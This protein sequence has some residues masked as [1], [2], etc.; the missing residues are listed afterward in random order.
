MRRVL[1]RTTAL[2][3]ALTMSSGACA[4]PGNVASEPLAGPPR[5]EGFEG[6]Q[7]SAVRPQTEPDLMAWDPGSRANL[8]R[9]RHRGVVAVRYQAKGC[10]VELELLSNCI[11][12][13]GKY[14]FSPYQANEHKVAHNASELFAELPLGAA[15]LSGKVKGNRALRTDYMLAG[16]Y[17]LPPDAMFR[18]ADLRGMDCA[19]ATHVVSTLYVGGFAM[20]AGEQRAMDGR[21]TLFGLGARGTAQADVE[22]L[23]DEGDPEACRA[24]QKER[25]E[26]EGCGVPL[27]VGLTA[28]DT[29]GAPVSEAPST[30]RAPV[31]VPSA[32]RTLTTKPAPSP[33]PA[34]GAEGGAM[35]NIPAGTY[36]MGSPDGE[37]DSDEH[38]RHQVTVAAFSMDVTEVTV[39]AY[40]RCVS[41][42]PCLPLETGGACNYG[43][44][45]KASHPIN[46]VAWDK[47]G[48]YCAWA[49]KRLPSEEEWEYAARGTD[50][51]TYPWG[52]EV[53]GARVCWN[54]AGND[55][56]PGKRSGTCPVGAY[57]AGKSPFG[58][59]DMS[60]NV[61]EWTSSGWSDAYG[62]SRTTS[63]RVGRGGGWSSDDPSR[64]R[65]ALRGRYEPWAHDDFLGFRCAR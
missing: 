24:S 18:R 17:A 59:L 7:C 57:P 9:L 65:G 51:R 25:K 44:S 45:D 61:R 11:G 6:V 8:S 54:G 40:A 26:N 15:R 46:C 50:G 30:G 58:L 32:P 36:W 20:A 43:K 53:P 28:L 23:C 62:T 60:G 19:R 21:A 34:D 2:G 16:Q 3:I 12:T 22:L 64:V 10:N 56:G 13:S 14:E 63:N 39:A 42:G 48:A 33:V 47:A 5:G 29:Q 4:P 38:P 1:G 49:G 27:R 35:V 31:A 37:G 41:A 55:L 52:Q